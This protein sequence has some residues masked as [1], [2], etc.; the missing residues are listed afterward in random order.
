MSFFCSCV[1]LMFIR[2][3]QGRSYE[4]QQGPDT[5]LLHYDT[6]SSINSSLKVLML[7]LLLLLLLISVK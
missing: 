3:A 2:L 6:N 7:L 1:K 4:G 5:P